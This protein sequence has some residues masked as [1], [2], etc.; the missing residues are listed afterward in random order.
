[1]FWPYLIYNLQ[2]T[3]KIAAKST[4]WPHLEEFWG[5]CINRH[6]D[7]RHSFLRYPD[8]SQVAFGKKRGCFE[9]P[10]DDK[11]PSRNIKCSDITPLHL[12]DRVPNR[13]AMRDIDPL[14]HPDS[15]ERVRY[16]LGTRM[17]MKADGKGSHK[18]A[19][20]TFH[21]LDLSEDGR[22][23]KSMTQGSH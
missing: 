15:D 4:I 12:S 20:C 23:L 2:S 7:S 22:M 18:A 14:V 9:P 16:C 6:F 5:Q 1:M 17:Q 13:E 19:T 10:S 21:D 3:M 11:L 8:H